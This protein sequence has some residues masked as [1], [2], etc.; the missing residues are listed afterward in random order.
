MKTRR[1][2]AIIDVRRTIS[3][4]ESGSARARV[5]SLRVVARGVI[6]A[7]T[8]LALVNVH[9]AKSSGPTDIA[10]TRKFCD[11]VRTSTMD[12]FS[13]AVLV[14]TLVNLVRTIRT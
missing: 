11:T 4:L 7:V 6:P 12:T 9:V 14:E 2:R 3:V 10:V 13:L 8:K 5:V 1:S